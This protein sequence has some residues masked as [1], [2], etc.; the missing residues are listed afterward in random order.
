MIPL[1]NLAW[2]QLATVAAEWTSVFA[3]NRASGHLISEALRTAQSMHLWPTGVA[4][5]L[6]NLPNALLCW[7]QF[8]ERQLMVHAPDADISNAACIL[9]HRSLVAFMANSLGKPA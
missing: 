9:V 6:L 1:N 2:G 5:S 4:F 7:K 3:A 8:C